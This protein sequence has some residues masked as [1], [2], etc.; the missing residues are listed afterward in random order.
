M[1]AWEEIEQLHG[2][3][4]CETLNGRFYIDGG[5]R[6][7]RK[8][9]GTF[10]IK[11]CM[12]NHDHYED[13][14]AEVIKAC[15]CE[16]WQNAVYLNALSVNNRRLEKVNYLVDLAYG[17]ENPDKLTALLE[18]KKMLLEKIQ[19]IYELYSNLPYVCNP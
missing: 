16:G 6:I 18:R 15:E 8:N 9:N 13:V 17:Y 10:T 14:T 3:F 1:K 5:L 11:N 19:G 4:I 2:R 12:T 7:E